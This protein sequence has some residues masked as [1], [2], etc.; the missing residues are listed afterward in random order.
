MFGFAPVSTLESRVIR[1]REEF[2]TVPLQKKEEALDFLGT[3]LNNKN[4]N[5]NRTTT[6]PVCFFLLDGIFGSD[7]SLEA[8]SYRRRRSTWS[9]SISVKLK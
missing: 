5:N 3:T 7:E 9:R 1:G 6:I 4:N 2:V 8:S